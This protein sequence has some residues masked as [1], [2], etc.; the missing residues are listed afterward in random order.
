MCHF[1]LAV[2]KILFSSLALDGLSMMYFSVDLLGLI[3]FVEFLGC[4]D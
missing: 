4:A 2:L 3:E 1:S